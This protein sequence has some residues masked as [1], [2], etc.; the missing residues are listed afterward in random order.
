MSDKLINKFIFFAAIIYLP[1]SIFFIFWLYLVTLIYTPDA[2]QYQ[3]FYGQDG[4]NALLWLFAVLLPALLFLL[5]RAR[6]KVLLRRSFGAA[7]FYCLLGSLISSY[8]FLVLPGFVFLFIS[9]VISR[10]LKK[11]RAEQRL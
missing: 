11:H 1:F 2:F 8:W 10:Q 7:G 6:G 4:N 5:S 9:I 3:V